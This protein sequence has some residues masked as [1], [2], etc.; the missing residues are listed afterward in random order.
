MGQYFSISKAKSQTFPRVTTIM[1]PQYRPSLNCVLYQQFL[2]HWLLMTYNYSMKFSKGLFSFS[3]ISPAWDIRVVL[4]LGVPK[5]SGKVHPSQR[6][7]DVGDGA[8]VLNYE[9][10]VGVDKGSEGKNN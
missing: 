4:V 7:C 2:T 10:E 6:W 8:P 3:A 1:L 5:L 9:G